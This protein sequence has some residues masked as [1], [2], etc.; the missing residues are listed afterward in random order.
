MRK[1]KLPLV[2]AAALA[3]APALAAPAA[4]PAAQQDLAAGAQR[5]AAQALADRTAWTVLDSLTTEVGPR[6]VGTPAMARARDWGVAT[7]KALGFENVHV[8]TFT[9]PAWTR[10]AESAEVVGPWPQKLHVLGLGRSPAT[11]PGGITAEIALFRSY[12]AFLDQPPG[13]LTGKIAVVTQEM[14]KTQSGEGYGAINAQRTLGPAEAA[15]RGA[16]AYLLRSLSTDDNREPHAGSAMAGVPAAA[17]SPVDADQLERMA[18]RGK[19]VTVHLELSSAFDPKAEAYNVVG[20]IRG[21]EAPDEVL[22]VGGH[23]DSWDPGTGAI[24]DAS[25]VA[26]MTAAARLAAQP[27]R[28]RR[29]IRVVM[30]GS[31]EQGGSGSAYAAAHKAEAPQIVVAGESDLGAGQIYA[32]TLPKGSAA[33]PAMTAFRSVL[34]ALKVIHDPQA[35]RFGGSDIEGLMG[36]GVPFVDFNQDATRYFDLHHSADDTLDK[37]KPDELAQ[38][39][40]VWAAFLYTVANSDIDFRKLA[41][42]TLTQEAP[43]P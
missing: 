35:P 37:V 38:N 3:A 42:V 28:P 29:T 20:E 34:P 22:V 39:V 4:A 40:A 30:W 24:D 14:R 27:A 36:L 18:A 2:V 7:L 33:S 23:L 43:K 15:K 8:E 9:T 16:V 19:P 17:L 32:L 25:G 26:I 31:E 10:G 11:P 12:Q 6:P 41:P 21:R 1:L 13:S 5:V